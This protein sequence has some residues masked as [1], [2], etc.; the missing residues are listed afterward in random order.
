M[1]KTTALMTIV[2]KA[3]NNTGET[4]VFMVA[5]ISRDLTNKKKNRNSLIN[6]TVQVQGSSV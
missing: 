1:S 2:M 3:S 6:F 4:V 5:K